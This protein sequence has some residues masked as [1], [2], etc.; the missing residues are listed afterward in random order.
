M[1]EKR[2]PTVIGLLLLLVTVITGLALGNRN[3]DFR[4][5]ASASCQPENIQISNITNSS[6]DIS[7]TTSSTCLVSLVFDNRTL[8]EENSSQV[9][10]FSLTNLKEKTEYGYSFIAGGNEYHQD[11]YKTKTGQKPPTSIPTSNLAW[12]RV[13]VTAQQNAS[14]GIVYLIIPQAGLLSSRITRNGN[15]NIPLATSFN[16][17]LT[18][19]FQSTADT[20]EDI[21]VISP[22]GQTTQIASSTSRN[23]PVPDIIIGQNSFSSSE[24]TP[25]T[26]RISPVNP[27]GTA[28]KNLDILNPKDN[29]TILN[30]KPQFFGT[31]PKNSQIIIRVESPETINDST[32]VLSDGSW[33]WSPPSDLSPGN[34]TITVSVQDPITGV[35]KT[36]SRKFVVLA[37]DSGTAFTASGSSQTNTPTP[38]ATSSPISSPTSRPTP[39][40]IATPTLLPTSTTIPSPTITPRTAKPSATSPPPVS[41]N[42]APTIILVTIAPVLLILAFLLFNY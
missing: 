16:S 27:A 8:P 3:T 35:I 17:Q 2:I 25:N 5:R 20:T 12:G 23:N 40:L 13:F 31:A 39:S 29:E 32:L 21:I 18:D 24:D 1:K 42:F 34:H 4:S 41:G 26:G 6:L 10:Y 37:S 19:W 38:T 30:L 36:I 28:D 14:D 9:H 22:D 7:F 11:T 33:R 15:W